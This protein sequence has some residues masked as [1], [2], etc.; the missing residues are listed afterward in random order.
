MI[1]VHGGADAGHGRGRRRRRGRVDG[2]G[3]GGDSGKDQMILNVG[4]DI[5]A[6]VP[7][8]FDMEFAQLK[9][10]VR[11]DESM[12]TVL[13]QELIRFNNL[14]DVRIILIPC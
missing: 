12:N 6:K 7:A 14:L 5:A 9:Y 10:Q 4:G 8:N 11:W 13:C 3:G 2:G 1:R